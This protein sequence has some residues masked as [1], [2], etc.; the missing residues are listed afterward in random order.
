VIG[1]PIGFTQSPLIHA[2]F[3]E[4]TGQDIV[5]EA[6]EGPL[7]GFAAGVDQFRAAGARGL[8]VTAPFKL[9]AFAYATELSESAKRAGAA[10]CLKFAGERVIAENFDGAGLVRDITVNLGVRMKGLRVLLLGAGGAARR[11]RR[12]ADA[13]SRSTAKTSA[14][15]AP[16]RRGKSPGSSGRWPMRGTAQDCRRR[17]RRLPLPT[18]PLPASGER[19]TKAP[20]APLPI[21]GERHGEAPGDSRG[22]SCARFPLARS[23][24][25]GER[26]FDAH[27]RP[28]FAIPRKGPY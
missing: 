14:R 22:K 13:S 2:A 27:K 11:S 18:Q 7:G 17:Q 12:R 1:N 24:L 8:N 19:G 4:A 9:D 25:G 26:A 16:R 6:I 10:N 3:A 15:C 23:A 5:Y 21:Y 28:S 20:A